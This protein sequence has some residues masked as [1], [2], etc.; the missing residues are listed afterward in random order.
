MM[1]GTQA[2]NLVHSEEI[3]WE[4]KK[5]LQ[6]KNRVQFDPFPSCQINLKTLSL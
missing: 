1:F 4:L 6:G 5:S 2:A 3:A